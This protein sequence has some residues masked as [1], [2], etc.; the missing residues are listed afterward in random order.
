M[1]LQGALSFKYDTEKCEERMTRTRIT[2]TR[3]TRQS[4]AQ[5]QVHN[6]AIRGILLWTP[7]PAM[8]K[9]RPPPIP[10]R[11]TRRLNLKKHWGFTPKTEWILW[12]SPH[13]ETLLGYQLIF[14]ESGVYLEWRNNQGF[15]AGIQD[16][17]EVT[18]SH[19]RTPVL[20]LGENTIDQARTAALDSLAALE[21]GD[22]VPVKYR[23]QILSQV[24][25]LSSSNTRVDVNPLSPE[26][27]AVLTSAAFR[28]A[29]SESTWSRNR[30]V[31]LMIVLAI[32]GVATL[33]WL[34]ARP[35][36]VALKFQQ[37]PRRL[38]AGTAGR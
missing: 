36:T 32:I 30:R 22:P 34:L 24:T 26:Q 31:R 1:M 37:P 38:E 28:Q 3:T 35:V 6:G 21:P 25:R 5:R 4:P 7:L 20:M 33:L 14:V 12:E 19:K 13:L 23:D 11:Y 15:S 10:Q 2:R 18:G 17:G 8:T 29:R 9:Q 16:D 27:E